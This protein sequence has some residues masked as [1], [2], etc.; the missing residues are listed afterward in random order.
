MTDDDRSPIVTPR[1]TASYLSEGVWLL[2][3]AHNI[4]CRTFGSREEVKAR[5]E[6]ADARSRARR[7]RS[8]WWSGVVRP[9]STAH[10]GQDA[11][12]RK[13]FEEDAD[14]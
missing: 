6:A 9:G 2:R 12:L 3:D 10:S 5:L 13:A 11:R 7:W 4:T 14:E 8:K 1:M